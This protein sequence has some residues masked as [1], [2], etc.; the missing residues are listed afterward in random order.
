MR[1]FKLTHLGDDRDPPDQR[2]V[3]QISIDTREIDP[4]ADMYT[5]AFAMVLLKKTP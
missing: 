2:R 1:L 4:I 3:V 5:V